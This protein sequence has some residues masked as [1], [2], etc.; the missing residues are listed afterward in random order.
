MKL[1]LI[2]LIIFGSFSVVASELSVVNPNDISVEKISGNKLKQRGEYSQ[3]IR[4]EV[5]IGNYIM[6]TCEN[7]SMMRL[8][9]EMRE[10]NRK[11]EIS[12]SNSKMLILDLD[13]DCIQA[14]LS[15]LSIS[16]V[17]E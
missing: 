16:S 10:L 17:V 1:L 4:L 12:Q 2:G 7:R 14:H 9:G 6:T 15:D 3:N 13:Q 8:D 11:I 5:T